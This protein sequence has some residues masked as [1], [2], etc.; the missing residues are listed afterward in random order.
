MDLLVVQSAQADCVQAKTPL[1][2]P[3]I[4][5]KVKL[6]GGMAIY[7]AIKA[8]HA[9]AGLRAFTVIGRIEFFLR[10]RRQQHLKPIKLHRRQ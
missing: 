4:G 10:K 5:T 8:G 9:Q 2:R 1:L 6:P 3:D 7:V